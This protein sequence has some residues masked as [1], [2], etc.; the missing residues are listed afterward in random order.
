MKSLKRFIVESINI[1]EETLV[2]E[3]FVNESF[4]EI[5]ETVKKQKVIR[6]Q[7]KV[8]RRYSTKPGYKIVNG[9]EV[10]MQ[11]DEIRNRKKAVKKRL[12][13]LK[14]KKRTSSE[15]KKTNKLR[16]KSLKVRAR[17]GLK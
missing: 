13:K 11:R 1:A 2:D 6:G 10:K 12:K 9:K 5:N 16:T 14:S 17:K 4:E 8:I 15:K 3:F 7:Q